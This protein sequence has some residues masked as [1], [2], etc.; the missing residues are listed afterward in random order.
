MS[1]GPIDNRDETVSKMYVRRF[2]NVAI[3]IY[4]NK[5]TR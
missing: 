3:E 2:D 1:V 5:K 4:D